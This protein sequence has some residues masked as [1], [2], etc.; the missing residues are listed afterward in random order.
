M[1][2]SELE[3]KLYEL[4]GK[5]PGFGIRGDNVKLFDD[6]MRTRQRNAFPTLPIDEF[7]HLFTKKVEE[8]TTLIRQW[9]IAKEIDPKIAFKSS[10]YVLQNAYKGGDSYLKSVRDNAANERNQ[11]RFGGGRGGRPIDIDLDL[12]GGGSPDPIP[13]APQAPATISATEIR[14]AVEQIANPQINELSS[15]LRREVTTVLEGSIK[16]LEPAMN[17]KIEHEVNK[18]ELGQHMTTQIT[19]IAEEAARKLADSLIPRRIEIG[20]PNGPIELDR[21]PRHEKFEEVLE[22]LISKSHVYIVG[23]KGTGKTHMGKQLRDALKVALD[24]PDYEVYFI[25]QSLT[26]YDVKGFKGPTGE[27]VDT[28]VRRAVEQ[29]HFLY[30]DEGDTWGAAALNSLNSILAND[31]GAFPD[32]VVEV[33]PD[34]RCVLAAN[35]FG[36]GADRQY[37]GRNPLDAA[38][39]DRFSF[40]VVDYDRKMEA[41]L[42]GVGAWTQYVWRVRD[43]CIQLKREDLMPSMR[44][45]SA[46]NEALANGMDVEKVASARLWRGTA[47][48]VVAKIKEIAGE[49]PKRLTPIREVA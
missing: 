16:N 41:Q 23:P 4:I 27:Y 29:G 25:D 46:G 5:Y 21:A 39:L 17:W 32:K 14:K 6:I 30:I 22:W 48:D 8:A 38:S 40:V 26:K 15:N 37:V 47:P 19:R 35:T 44:A 28:L 18:L 33:H 10:A 3:Q 34:F 42:Y 9:M 45:I 11:K 7:N 31:F 36:Q 12:L 49:P 43:A 2:A 20:K 1:T 13:Q 24:R